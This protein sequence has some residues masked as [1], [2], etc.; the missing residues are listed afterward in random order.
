MKL[1]ADK[2]RRLAI[3]LRNGN[4]DLQVIRELN[5]AAWPHNVDP[6]G[7]V[8]T[9]LIAKYE[10]KKFIDVSIQFVAD[11]IDPDTKAYRVRGLTHWRNYSGTP[12]LVEYRG[13]RYA[14]YNH[15]LNCAKGYEAEIDIKSTVKCN[16]PDFIDPSLKDWQV[17]STGRN[18][19]RQPMPTQYFE[20]FPF[21]IIQ[22]F[23][24]QIT[25][26]DQK[27]DCPWHPFRLRADIAWST[28]DSKYT[29]FS[30]SLAVNM[31]INAT[32][33][34]SPWFKSETMP[35]KESIEAVMF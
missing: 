33:F 17:V 13:P 5:P 6:G 2:L 24:R 29:P 28:D 11:R 25:I 16:L 27:F 19:Y 31:T 18:P 9:G 21:V 8:A 30:E 12:E 35:A 32:T 22:C 20:V 14:I 7:A 26:K 15:A 4:I 1:V 23:T 10:F 3:S 34:N